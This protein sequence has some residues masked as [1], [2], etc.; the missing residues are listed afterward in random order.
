M[1]KSEVKS[2]SSEVLTMSQELQE[3]N[4]SL[5]ATVKRLIHNLAK[6]VQVHLTKVEHEADI[7]GKEIVPTSLSAVEEDK[8]KESEL[9]EH[10]VDSITCTNSFLQEPLPTLEVVEKEQVVFEDSLAIV[11]YQGATLNDINITFSMQRVMP[12]IQVLQLQLPVII[13]IPLVEE[14]LPIDF[15]FRDR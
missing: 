9:V 12:L 1:P 5:N 14:V 2:I 6:I 4:D 10:E 8:P 13:A 7:S 3:L 15:V 11:P